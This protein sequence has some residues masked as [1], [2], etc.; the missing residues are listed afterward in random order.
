MPLPTMVGYSVCSLASVNIYYIFHP[1]SCKWRT[2]RWKCCG[3]G[4]SPSMD[5]LCWQWSAPHLVHTYFPH[6]WHH[7][8]QQ[9]S[10]ASL[11]NSQVLTSITWYYRQLRRPRKTWRRSLEL[12]MTTCCQG[13]SWLVRRS[14]LLTLLLPATSST[15]M[16]TTVTKPTASLTRMWPAGSPPLSISLNSKRFLVTLS[17]VKK[18]V[19]WTPR[20][21][22]NSLVSFDMF[23]DSCDHTDGVLWD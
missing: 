17:F 4:P 8:I 18:N 12:S 21:L 23:I 14:H 1:F 11:A 9:S 7:A 6:P 15:C 2:P 19:Q 22:L 5:E 20:S 3:K 16:S 10:M 13:P